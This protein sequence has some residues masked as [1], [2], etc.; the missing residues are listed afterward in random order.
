MR[1]ILQKNKN[2][3]PG[4]TVQVYREKVNCVAM[5]LRFFFLYIYY[6]TIKKKKIRSYK[7]L[8]ITDFDTRD[9]LN[10]CF[11]DINPGLCLTYEMPC[12][13]SLF[14][15]VCSVALKRLR[16]AATQCLFSALRY[17]ALLNK[18]NCFCTVSKW[19][20]KEYVLHRSIWGWGGLHICDQLNSAQR[21]W[22][23]QREVNHCFFCL[24]KRLYAVKLVHWLHSS[25]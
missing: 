22:L 1:S 9:V 4:F 21:P 2:N 19:I 23:K 18:M 20:L 14:E 13:F 10:L 17:V 6:Y 16:S 7:H 15:D 11:P 12:Y 5:L 3:I 25:L 8:S 24:K